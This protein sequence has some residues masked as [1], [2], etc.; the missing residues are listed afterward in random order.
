MSSVATQEGGFAHQDA[1]WSKWNGMHDRTRAILFPD[2]TVRQ[3][4]TNW[5]LAAKKIGKLENTS[6]TAAA[7]AILRDKMV[8][9]G[10]VGATVA[11]QPLAGIGAIGALALGEVAS[12][13]LAKALRNPKLVK[14]LTQELTTPV[15]GPVRSAVPKVAPSVS[16]TA[17]LRPVA[18]VPTMAAAD[19]S[20]R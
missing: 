10:A 9:S 13:G 11:G 20:R 16:A 18:Q 6:G 8:L 12:V 4:I 3:Q 2:A 14:A 5:L 1:L 7:N 19:E 15:R 17:A